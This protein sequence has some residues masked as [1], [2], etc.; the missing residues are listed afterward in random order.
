MNQ[1]KNLT[2]TI[3]TI[4]IVGACSDE[5]TSKYANAEECA[6]KESKDCEDKSCT[7]LA[8]KYC[9]SSFGET[10]IQCSELIELK[11]FCS[12]D[13]GNTEPDPSG[14]YQMMP[15]L[16]KGQ[17]NKVCPKSKAERWILYAK[18]KINNCE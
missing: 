5:P 2:I 7:N 14:T 18:I 12:S 16:C 11:Q 15:M 9:E 13:C 3:I 10:E 8:V 17:K 1:I 4:L 6:F